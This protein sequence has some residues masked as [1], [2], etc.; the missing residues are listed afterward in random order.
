[1]DAS[2]EFPIHFLKIYIC[3]TLSLSVC[4]VTVRVRQQFADSFSCKIGCPLFP[5]L[6]PRINPTSGAC[7]TAC[8]VECALFGAR[9]TRYTIRAHLQPSLGGQPE[10]GRMA[11]VIGAG[12]LGQRLALHAAVERLALLVGGE[13]RATAES[14]TARLRAGADQLA[15]KLG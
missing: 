3:N 14:D 13:L 12:D 8:I 9:G 7:W 6:N 4:R 5:Y 15:L 2:P 11:H 1:M 10:N